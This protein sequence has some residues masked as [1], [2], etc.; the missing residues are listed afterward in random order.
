M[1]KNTLFS[2][3]FIFSIFYL[4]TF[5]NSYC[6]NNKVASKTVFGKTIKASSINPKN[7]KIRCSTVEY[8]KYLQKK[9]PKRLTNAQFESWVAPLVSRQAASRI[10]SKSVAATVI[11]IPVVVHVIHSGQAIGTAPNILDAQVQ[12]QIT[13]LNQ[14]YRKMLGTPGHNTNAVG[15]DVQIEFVLAKQDPKGNPTNGIDRVNMSQSSW[16][17]EEIN[18]TVKPA[19]IWNPDEYLNMWTV[20]FS[21]DDLLGYAQFP[22]SSGLLGTEDFEGDANTDGVVSSFDVFGSKAFGNN[23]LLVSPYDKGRTMSHEVGHFFGLRHIWG[24]GEGDEENNN[25]DCTATDYCADTPQAGWA[26]YDCKA[27]YNT[28]PEVAGNDMTANYMDYTN[29]DCMN[30]FTQNQKDRILTVLKNS[31]RRKTLSASPRGIALAAVAND[32]EIK[33]LTDYSSDNVTSCSSLPAPTNKKVTITNRG[34]R[35][36]TNV[37]IKYSLNGG[38]DQFQTWTGSLAQNESTVVTLLNTASVGVLKANIENTNGVADERAGNN[39]DSKPYAP[40]NYNQV[41]F[42]FT[43]QNDLYGSE[44]TWTLK[45]GSGTIKYKGGPYRDVSSTVLPALIKQNW[46]LAS[47]QCYTFFIEDT[48][49]DGICCG[50][51][52]GYYNIKPAGSNDTVAAGTS[53]GKSDVVFFT[54]NTSLSTDEFESSKEV[55]VYPNPTTATLSIQIPSSLGL[56]KAYVITNV[57]GQTIIEKNIS[58]EGDLN[59]NTSS[60]SNGFY[61]I[62]LLKGNQRRTLEFI[63]E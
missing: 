28:C 54:T 20:K 13:V 55:F 31:E 38:M 42:V 40:I 4:L 47:N 49:A 19:T 44:V 24:D 57:L 6:Q 7:G 51:G 16:S 37:I 63:K 3:T 26:H 41:N 35:V 32:S 52:I 9:N 39:I 53:Y 5:N 56:P 34:T 61:F 14:D 22:S 60:L 1:K 59:V 45:D 8:E 46:T 21:A 29:D 36:L 10:S 23:F 30:I 43:L 2:V 48:E 50:G 62:T 12:S 17:D 11:S 18:E 33:A 15:A 58:T 27:T 25:P